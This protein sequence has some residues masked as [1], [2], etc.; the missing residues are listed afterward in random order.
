MNYLCNEMKKEPNRI[1]EKDLVQLT[2]QQRTPITK[3]EKRLAK[4]IKAIKDKG[5]I[6]EIPG[7]YF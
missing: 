5:L 6:V 3:K 2:L 1:Q 7:D 4:Q